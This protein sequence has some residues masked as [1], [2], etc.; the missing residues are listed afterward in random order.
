[1]EA[2]DRVL[3]EPLRQLGPSLPLTL[4]ALLLAWLFLGSLLLRLA[5]L[6]SL[7]LRGDALA[8]LFL[9]GLLSALPWVRSLLWLP[10]AWFAV[11]WVGSLPYVTGRAAALATPPHAAARFLRRGLLADGL[12]LLACALFFWAQGGT[13]SRAGSGY[14]ADMPPTTHAPGESRA[15]VDSALPV[16][17]LSLSADAVLAPLE[18]ASSDRSGDADRPSLRTRLQGKI[19][20][21]IPTSAVLLALCLSALLVKLASAEVLLRALHARQVFLSPTIR[22]A[23]GPLL[24][25]LAPLLLA[26]HLW[27]CLRGLW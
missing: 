9:V 6:A 14:I 19:F 26:L 2:V 16:M 25:A 10:L 27:L 11:T 7:S 3:P 24:L 12:L 20:F 1:M 8:R 18:R 23:T 22:A 4:F 17:R 13:W 5:P 21:G 15:P